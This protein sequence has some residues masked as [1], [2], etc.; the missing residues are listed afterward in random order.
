MLNCFPRSNPPQPFFPTTDDTRP[1]TDETPGAGKSKKMATTQTGSQ[2]GQNWNP[3]LGAAELS[4]LIGTLSK[5]EKQMP[6]LVGLGRGER[7][8]LPKV[9]PLTRSF[10]A[11]ALTTAQA[12]P[13]LLPRSIDISSLRSRA[14]T[15]DRLGEVRRA[16]SQFLEK[17]DDTEVL[18]ASEVYA[19]ARTVYAV[20]KTPAAVP[21]LKDRQDR[22]AERFARKKGSRK[23][24][25][26]V[27]VKPQQ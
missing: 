8:K 16:V 19:A 18:L 20:M 15:L 4:S 10:V 11:D 1:L 21:G 24:E 23:A 27:V 3:N 5:I 14:D 26:P 13:G 9:G 17:V 25:E 12:N 22:L 2:S 6:Y 7:R